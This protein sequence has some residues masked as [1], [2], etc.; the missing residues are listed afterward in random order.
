[1]PSPKIVKVRG[2][3]GENPGPLVELPALIGD[4]AARKLF[5]E[6]GGVDF[7][8]PKGQRNNAAGAAR[9]RQLSAVVGVEAAL[10]IC[11]KYGGELIYI[12][13]GL[14]RQR[15]ERN[16]KI[17]R[18][19]DQGATVRELVREFGLGQRQVEIVLNSTVIKD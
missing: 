9:F 14:Q 3:R 8:V 15:A 18:R 2:T 12:P 16:Q 5:A 11:G 6:L 13:T 10:L 17:C 1:M 4:E 7:P 19:F